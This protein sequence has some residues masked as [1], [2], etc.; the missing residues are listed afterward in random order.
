MSARRTFAILDKAVRSADERR[1][2]PRAQ[3]KREGGPMEPTLKGTKA[4]AMCAVENNRSDQAQ[5]E[6]A[7]SQLTW[8]TSKG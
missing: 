6:P 7:V 2:R 8:P 5:G 3:C 4:T 1:T